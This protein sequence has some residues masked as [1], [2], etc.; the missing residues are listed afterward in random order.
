MSV[1]NDFSTQLNDTSLCIPLELKYSY[2][3]PR[4][5]YFHTDKLISPQSKYLP[6]ISHIAEQNMLSDTEV[7]ITGPD[8]VIELKTDVVVKHTSVGEFVIP[9]GI[10]VLPQDI[11]KFGQIIMKLDDYKNCRM[12]YFESN[13]FSRRLKLI[14]NYFSNIIYPEFKKK[15]GNNMLMSTNGNMSFINVD[16]K[17]NFEYKSYTASPNIEFTPYIKARVRGYELS[18]NVYD[19]EVLKTLIVHKYELAE[20]DNITQGSFDVKIERDKVEQLRVFLTKDSNCVRSRA[21]IDIY[22]FD[23]RVNFELNN[24]YMFGTID[25]IKSNLFEINNELFNKGVITA[26][27]DIRV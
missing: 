23:N 16:L 11:F 9:S 8:L 26:P 6:P 5:I 27:R 22:D 13:D 3:L 24:Q 21:E 25:Y 19:S 17:N 2:K 14:S 4:Y 18:V 12:R 7:I 1:S 20:K 10:H 15:D